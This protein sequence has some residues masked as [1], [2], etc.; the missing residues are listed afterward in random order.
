MQ[1]PKPGLIK[2]VM[3]L[4]PKRIALMCGCALFSVATAVSAY[5]LLS[6]P[7]V[8]RSDVRP[9]SLMTPPLVDQDD[10]ETA[11]MTPSAP[12]YSEPQL[13]EAEQEQPEPNIRKVS[14]SVSRGDTL[15]KILDTQ[16]I[17]RQ[18][19]YRALQALQSVFDPR[20]LTPGQ[21]IKFTL[22]DGDE[23]ETLL[24]KLT[25]TPAPGQRSIVSRQADGTFVSAQEADPINVVSKGYKGTITSS[26][27]AAGADASMTP[28]TIQRLIKLFSYD[29]D[30]QREIREGDTF[31]VMVDQQFLP[32]GTLIDEGEIDFASITLSGTT[33]KL[34][35][36]EDKD[37]FVD[38]YNEKGQSARKA[39]LRT[40]IDGARISSNYGRRKHPI[41]GYTK[42][43]KGVDF[44]AP[45][46]TPVYAA[47]DGI[48][49]KSQWFGGYGKYVKLRHNSTYSTA[50]AHLS[51]F[52]KG[53]HPGKR[54]RQGQIIAYSGNTGR[55]TGPHLHYEI[56]RNGKHVNPLKVKM[57]SGRKLK[58]AEFTR[59][60]EQ[61]RV[62]DRSFAALVGK[63]KVA[64]AASN[65]TVTTR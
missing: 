9:T 22:Q 57:P 7:K 15:G 27:F 28:Q 14:V 39:L 58:G 37:G 31:E 33:L 32:D 30:F 64:E 63:H 18:E 36:F 41:L 25:I 11:A 21:K 53:I 16:N 46:G 45:R 35:R 24:S 44:A 29:V 26:L 59:F 1:T 8:V 43:H 60:A 2:T 42:M 61:R 62:L 23:G 56:L 19:A 48:I 3:Q 10:T 5:S 51:R 17:S 40:P 50:Y 13:A 38:Y 12:V 47:G 20:Q 55:S 4:P 54:V 34:Y 6:S 49:S 65:D 52:A